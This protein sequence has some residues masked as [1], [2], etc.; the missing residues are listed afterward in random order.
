MMTRFGLPPGFR[1]GII[2]GGQLARMSAYEAFKLGIH[3]GAVCSESGKDPMEQVTPTVFRGDVSDYDTLMKLAEW[4][5][6]ITLENEFLDGEVLERVQRD[7]GK[8]VYPSPKSFKL[9]ESKRLEKETFRD[10]GIPVADFVVVES[11]AAIQKTGARLGWPFILKSSKGGYDGYGNAVVS[12]Q[13]EAEKA[14]R[15]FGGE[16][17]REVIAE[18]MVDFTKEL[19]VM[20]ARNAHGMVSFPCCETIQHH[21]ICAKVLAP[22]PISRRLRDEC[23]ALAEKAI[24]AIDG[25]GIFGFEFFLTK[26]NELL[27][28]ESAPRP[29]NSGH[30][31]MEACSV[32]QFETHVRAVCGLPLIKP[33]MRYPA[34][35]MVNLLG[36]FNGPAELTL[37]VSESAHEEVHLHVYGKSESRLGR[38]MGHITV[39]GNNPE[40]TLDTADRL[41]KATVL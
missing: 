13:A 38:K 9:I 14:F 3:V 34:A 27:L 4:A 18:E 35:V 29:H 25:I 23:V 22:A 7:S 32:S 37:P 21:H 16:E 41:E 20:V 1:L 11:T 12:N 19:A 33:V 2:G 6:V 28:N 8:P 36:K 40:S 26:D 10:A 5:D 15:N 24:Q 30:F 31:S 39:L 17:G